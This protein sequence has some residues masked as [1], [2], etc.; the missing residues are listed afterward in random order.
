LTDKLNKFSTF[1]LGI[2][3]TNGGN[4]R[5]RDA[6]RNVKL[7]YQHEGGT[8]A[9]NDIIATTTATASK[10][11]AETATFR[12]TLP[13]DAGGLL[14]RAGQ[15]HGEKIKNLLEY[16]RDETDEHDYGSGVD[17]DEEIDDL[18]DF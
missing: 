10:T 15:G 14:G 13:R 16:E 5:E 8:T 7:A 2:N 3:A 9:T 12:Q 17:T 4:Q 18:D 1:N 6:K 11:H